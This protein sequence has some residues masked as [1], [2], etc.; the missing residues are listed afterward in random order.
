LKGTNDGTGEELAMEFNPTHLQSR[1]L[2][3]TMRLSGGQKE[4]QKILVYS[5]PENGL[6]I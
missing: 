6:P 3:K 1:D 5:N 4:G 2:S